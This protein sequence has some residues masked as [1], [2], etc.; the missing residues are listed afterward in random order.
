MELPQICQ[1]KLNSVAW[2]EGVSVRHLKHGPRVTL[3]VILHPE[4][5]Q[6]R[7]GQLYGTSVSLTLWATLI[8]DYLLTVL[9]LVSSIV[10]SIWYRI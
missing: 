4:T 8:F 6:V 9:Y 3:C 2:G 7:K 5:T 10:F 1:D